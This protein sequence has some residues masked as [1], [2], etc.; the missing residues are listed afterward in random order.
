LISKN[1]STAGNI[2]FTLK[3]IR[4]I[5]GL[6]AAA[7]L[8]ATSLTAQSP[9]DL[10]AQADELAVHGKSSKAQP[11]YLQAETEFRKAGDS[12]NEMYARFG[13]LKYNVQL[14]SYTA[15]R[16]ESPTNSSHSV[17]RGRSPSQNQR[18]GNIGDD[19]PEPKHA[20]CIQ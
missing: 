2:F 1:C 12:R 7:L 11:L 8:A 18:S 10:L 20:G 15:S 5:V 3:P 13:I 14:G 4:K 16:E 9:A 17:G 6:I 19:R